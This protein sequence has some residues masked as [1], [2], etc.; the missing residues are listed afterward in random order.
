MP[1]IPQHLSPGDTVAIV[2]PASPPPDA[3]NIDRGV[4]AVAALG[5]KVKLASHARSR[6]G[7][8]AD[9]DRARAADLMRMFTDKKVRAIL[10]FRGGHGVTRLLSR[11]DFNVIRAN[12][13]I[14]IGYSDVTALLNALRARA[15]LVCFH[16]PMV[17]ADFVTHQLPAF[18]REVFLRTL[19]RAAAPGGICQGYTGKTVSILRRGVA[20]GELMGGNLTMLCATLGTP[21]QPAFRGKIVFFEDV[22]EAPFRYDRML[23][24]LLNAGL[25]QQAA[26]VAVGFNHNCVDRTAVEGGEYRQTLEDVL[27]ERL[28]PL[29]V[30]VVIGLP[31]GH[32]PDNATLPVG[33]RATLDGRKGDLI[34]AT[35]AVR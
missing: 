9:S 6:H 1:V 17:N 30:P 21:W 20:H 31:F 10:A 15:N 23:T 26:G 33:L 4:A 8:L 27:R 5:F 25:L 13:K 32:G 22:N 7:F 12:P 2:S 35:R 19:T 28:L 14:F 3:A 16:G 11:L 29:R 18:V 24:Q 34:F